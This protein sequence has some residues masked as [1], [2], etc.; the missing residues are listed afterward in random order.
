VTLGTIY[1]FTP[2]GERL[3]T[4]HAG[5]GHQIPDIPA[6]RDGRLFTATNQGDAIALDME[7][8]AEVWRR[9]VGN[10]T[11]GDTW[12]MTAADDIVIAATPG[13]DH[14]QN[15]NHRFVAMHASDGSEAWHFDPD[16]MIYNIL[17]SVKDG[18]AVFSTAFGKVY[19]LDLQT[20]RVIWK[21]PPP[22]EGNFA[23]STGGAMIGSNGIV[24]VTWN[25]IRFDPGHAQPHIVPVGRVGAYDFET[26][27][28]IWTADMGTF[29]ANNAA[30]VG[31]SGPGGRLAVVVGVGSNP[32]IPRLPDVSDGIGPA[33]PARVVALDAA[34]G[35]EFWSYTMPTWHGSALDDAKRPDICLPD[36]FSN[37]AIGGDGTVYFGFQ[38]GNFYALKDSNEDGTVSESEVSTWQTGAA[39]QGSPGIAPGM[40]V[41]TP[42]N[43]MHVWRTPLQDA[44]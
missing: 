28:R 10:A 3:W 29:Q 24:Y 8:G 5:K 32:D 43:G 38:N 14:D 9:K 13:V 4:Y 21:T 23:M 26:G 15:N 44:S 36:A 7:T 22:Q 12:S 6:I 33:H 25:E 11:A 30:T 1:K 19:S 31:P 20:G 16:G 18:R 41:A 39:F 27:N 37:A 40:V 17:V 35:A 34:T 2:D 42:C